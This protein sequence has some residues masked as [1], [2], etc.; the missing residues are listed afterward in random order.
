MIGTI[1]DSLNQAPPWVSYAVVGVMLV[2]A[3]GVIAWQMSDPTATGSTGDKHFYCA[4]CDSGFTVSAEDAREA[5]R[6]AAK[7]NPG[8]RP[9]AKCE[10]CGKFTC[11]IGKKCPKC[12]TY[13]AMPEKSG[14]LFPDSWRD[15]CPKCG[16]SAQRER[17][18]EAALKQKK[19]GKYDPNKI[20]EFI[21][22]AVEEAEAKG[23]G[24]DK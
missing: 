15:E 1:R 16:Y 5:L 2:L 22:E 19:E 4:D 14:S 12:N 11:V 10:K 17:A 9:L 6:A 20:P 8:S 7:A 23:E 13:F 18:V 3:I 21:R 24:G